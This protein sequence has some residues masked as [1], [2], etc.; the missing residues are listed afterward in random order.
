ML[1]LQNNAPARLDLPGLTART[2]PIAAVTAKFDLTFSL[3]EERAARRARRPGHHRLPRLRHRP[4]RPGQHEALAARL[5]R[6]SRATLAAPD[7]P[8]GRL[9]LL[10]AAERH[11][12]CAT[13]TT[14]RV[15]VEPDRHCLNCLLPRR[16]ARPMRSPWC[17]KTETLTYGELDARANQLAHHL[18][19]LGVGP[20]TIVGLC[21]ER[22]LDMVIGLLGILKAGGAYLPLDPAYPSQRLAFMLD[23]ARAR[24]VVTQIVTY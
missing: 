19:S 2:E 13:G 14:P 12:S 23:D 11:I 15:A 22:S 17:S 4:V 5:V 1:V 7:R 18:Q 9:D 21:V 20:E 16:A 8:I 6:L 10:A 24:L 3:G